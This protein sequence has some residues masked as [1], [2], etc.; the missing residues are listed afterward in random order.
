MNRGTKFTKMIELLSKNKLQ[1]Q[2]YFILSIVIAGMAGMLYYSDNLI[3]QQFIAGTNPLIAC[4]AIVITGFILLSFLLYK[5]WFAI[6]IKENL[7]KIFRSSCLALLFV[8]I[9]ILVDSKVGFPADMNILF[10]QS[11][12]FYPV[13][14]FFVEILF[15]VLPLSLLLI[16]MASIFKK[17]LY[18]NIAGICV[19][20]V[21]LPE[22]IYQTMLMASTNHY[23][24]WSL[25]IVWF[26]LFLFNL[27]Q[28][29]IFKRY[30][31]ISMY[32]FRL[33]YY[34]AWHMIWGY[35]RLQVLSF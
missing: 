25:V 28:L 17:A 2:F 34:L 11:L 12:F 21:S 19:F 3:F 13:I 32:S 15:H 22:P 8:P 9:S 10:P 30:D 6:Y 14:G 16:L 26:N 1:Y 33:M 23:P 24:L 5:D 20:I 27:S 35:I 18:K 29:I 4:I 7:K 31:F